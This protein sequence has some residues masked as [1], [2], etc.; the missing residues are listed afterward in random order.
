MSDAP[1]LSAR[2]EQILHSV[3]RAYIDSGEPVASQ[4]ISRLRR[5]HLSPASV[6][7]VMAE[8]AEQGYLHQPH[9][10]AGRVPT[11]KAYALYV[12]ALANRRPAMNEVGRIREELSQSHTVEERVERSSRML[13]G[14]SNG[15]G[16]AA[17]IPTSSQ[18]FDQVE[19][20]LMGSTRVLMIVVTRDKMIHDQL[21]TLDEA[22]SQDELTTI[23]NYLNVNF[24]G[25]RL[26]DIRCELRKRL[27]QASAAYDALL[28]KLI[29]LYDKGLLEGTH[30]PEFHM[31]GAANLVSFD[32]Q[33]TRERLREMFR[34]LEEKK[35]IIKLLER[36]LEPPLGEVVVQIGMADEDP[37]L[38][39]LSLIG[40]SLRMPGGVTGKFA[41]IGPMRMDY[42]RA[43]AAVRHVGQAYLSLPS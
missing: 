36:F 40:I 43:F 18:V 30:P 11:T 17:A 2:A 7:N 27:D 37:T 35:R 14:L 39:P 33:L 31:E 13:T 41:V 34:T 8:L 26:A 3:V 12:R 28:R 42:E 9:T 20:I 4:D 21:M 19:L 38:S 23:R 22:V 10:S 24:S 16:I 32:F 6:R 29:L 25:W 5:H 15:L 1:V